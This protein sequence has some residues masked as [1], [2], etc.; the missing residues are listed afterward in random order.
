MNGDEREATTPDDDQ[1]DVEIGAQLAGFAALNEG[2]R[3][4]IFDPLPVLL[5]AVSAPDAL[6]TLTVENPPDFWLVSVPNIANVN[7]AVHYG[8]GRGPAPVAKLGPGGYCRVP[9]RGD[10]ITLD[11]LG[12]AGVRPVVV[13]A[14]GWGEMS[15]GD[16]LVV[17]GVGTVSI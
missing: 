4:R 5:G 6:Q 1:P 15:T 7:V 9:G 17:P 12:S 10:A 14:S 11:S 8:T 13:A 16:I 3:H 2:K